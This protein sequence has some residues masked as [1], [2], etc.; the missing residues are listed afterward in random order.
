[1]LSFGGTKNG[2]LGVEAVLV[3]TGSLADAARY[4]RKQQMQ[5]A[6]KMRFLGA[7]ATALLADGLWLAS[8]SHAN[9]MAAR[10]ASALAA[11]P[12]IRIAYPVQANSVFTEVD[13][14]IAP[15]LEK[16]F[17]IHVWS[18][19]DSGSCIVRWMTAFDTSAADVDQLA[20]AV[21]A[22]IVSRET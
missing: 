15:Q 12:G 8:A 7:Q 20:A 22:S 21:K 2:A 11:V 6:S 1:V 10:L 18:E 14:P 3:M 19:G 13:G 17:N 9:A 4:H 5:L 16:D